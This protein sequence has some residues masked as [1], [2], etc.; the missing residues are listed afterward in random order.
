M[1]IATENTSPPRPPVP[2]PPR[3][4]QESSLCSSP[5]AGIPVLACTRSAVEA[6]CEVEGPGVQQSLRSPVL[7]TE[8]T[9]VHE[10]LLWDVQKTGVG[11]KVKGEARKSRGTPVVLMTFH[12]CL[13]TSDKQ[14]LT[15]T[16]F[17]SKVPQM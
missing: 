8:D 17:L 2:P 3:A 9:S 4:F 7:G 12:V 1:E 14:V 10:G 6:G 5:N 11:L 13:P 15:V 16:S